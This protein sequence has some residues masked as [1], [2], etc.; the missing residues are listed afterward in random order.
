VR[1]YDVHQHLWPRPLLD[2]LRRRAERPRLRDGVLELDEGSFPVDLG[3]HDLERRLAL[4]DR[5]AIDVAV[6]SLP[7]T[8]CWEWDPELADAYHEGILD[9]ARA[10]RGRLLPLACGA[11]L[12]GFAGAC[13]SAAAVGA[14]LGPLP[15]DLERAGQVLFVHPGPCARAPAGAPPWWNAVVSYTA[16]MQA[17]YYAW[18]AD[19]AA[20]SAAPAVVFA[21]LAGGAP[22]QLER[23]RSRGGEYV[24]DPNLY[25]ETA[26]Y[27]GK[28][29]RLCLEACGAERLLYGSDVPVVD[30]RPTLR[31]L[32][33][34]GE[35]VEH[36]AVV[37]NPARLF[38]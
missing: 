27:G 5:D 34:L 23:V 6:V 35:D 38:G 4:L 18:H 20:G 22:F 33:A 19:G 37:E 1:R 11:C 10:A 13:V 32:A 25:L 2:A 9:V 17:A 24:P 12:D 31:A 16:Q 26:S 3:D 21:V 36:A 7:P 29:L 15:T 28:A 14:G 8:L 30:P